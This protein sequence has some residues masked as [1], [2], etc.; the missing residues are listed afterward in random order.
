MDMPRG[1]VGV[2]SQSPFL[3]AQFLLDADEELFALGFGHLEVGGD[4]LGVGLVLFL[5]VLG[6]IELLFDGEFAGVVVGRGRGVV[7]GLGEGHSLILGEE[8]VEVEFFLH[9]NSYLNII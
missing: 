7:D 2:G 4:G 3:A 8:V 6:L 5:I 9:S 1:M